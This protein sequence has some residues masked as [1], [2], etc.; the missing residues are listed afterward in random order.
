MRVEAN[1][2]DLQVFTGFCS[3]NTTK[4]SQKKKKKKKTWQLRKSLLTENKR[5]RTAD[6]T[7]GGAQTIRTLPSPSQ[8]KSLSLRGE[9]QQ[10]LS[11]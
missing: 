11:P 4:Y 5:K 3:V 10:T 9:E 1:I 7:M 6:A 8:S 2:G